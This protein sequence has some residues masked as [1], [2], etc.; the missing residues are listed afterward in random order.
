MLQI[1]MLRNDML[2]TALMLAAFCAAAAG[3]RPRGMVALSRCAG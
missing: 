2:P 3:V 1:I